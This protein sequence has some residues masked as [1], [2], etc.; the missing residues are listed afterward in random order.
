MCSSDLSFV[1]YVADGFNLDMHN[2]LFDEIKNLDKKKIKFVLSNAKVELVTQ[3]F[4]NYNCEDI[5]AR[6]AIHSKKPGST[7]TEVIIFN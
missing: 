4:K 7:T 1:G 3:A 2:L 5:I 6:R